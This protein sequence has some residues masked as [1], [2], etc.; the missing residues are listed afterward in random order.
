MTQAQR[1][2][3]AKF[4]YPF[5]TKITTI[6]STVELGDKEHFDKVQIGVKEPFSV[7]KCHF[8]S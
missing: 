6:I 1:T 7:T 4:K 3:E 8:T 2:Q 5:P